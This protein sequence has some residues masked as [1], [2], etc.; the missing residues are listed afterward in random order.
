MVPKFVEEEGL[1]KKEIEIPPYNEVLKNPENMKEFKKYIKDYLEP[2]TRDFSEKSKRAIDLFL[3]GKSVNDIA[4]ELEMSAI[5]I[6]SIKNRYL[7]QWYE[8][9]YENKVEEVRKVGET[10]M[11]ITADTV[12]VPYKTPEERAKENSCP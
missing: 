6:R 3:E 2:K 9:W 1:T 12:K 7:D 4:S 5:S 8:E 10:F 11:S